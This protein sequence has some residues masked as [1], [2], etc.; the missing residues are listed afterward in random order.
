MEQLTI[1]GGGA[2][3]CRR[4]GRVL[5]DPASVKAGI[6]PVCVAKQEREMQRRHEGFDQYSHCVCDL[7][8]DPGTRDIQVR[9]GPDDRLHFNIGQVHVWH[10]P[11]GFEWGYHG[12]GPSDFALNILALF[13]PVNIERIDDSEIMPGSKTRV[14]AEV[15]RLHQSFKAEFVARL[16]REG[17]VISGQDIQ[18]WVEAH[19]EHRA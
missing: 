19:G 8:W 17:G 4:C 12:S 14:H 9:R 10:S 15:A 5:T 7:P 1:F 3:T 13:I 18:R 11:T 6:G 16:P 2:T